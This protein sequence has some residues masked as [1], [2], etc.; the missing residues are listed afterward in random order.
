M[1]GEAACAALLPDNRLHLQHGPIDLVIDIEAED[2]REVLAARH[3]A[4]ARF[5]DVLST[6]VAELP[7]LRTR[8]G[9]R[10][11]PLS[12][13]VA[14]RMLAACWPHRDVY[15]T[16]MAA[17]AG[18]V[19]DEI[20][21]ASV[22]DRTLR[23]VAVNNGGDIALHLAAGTTFRIGLAGIEDAQL[24]GVVAIPAEHAVRGVATSGWRGRSQSLGIADAVTVLARDAASADVA[25]TLVANAVNVDH[26]AVHRLPAHE[27]RDDSD[28]GGLPVTVQVDAL[29][30]EAIAMALDAGARTAHRL[31]RDGWIHAACLRLQGRSSIV[32]A[33]GDPMMNTIR[34][35]DGGVH[36]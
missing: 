28:L 24:H 8:L 1:N 16:P 5:A 32:A 4:I 22:R 19:A 17:V 34:L 2:E 29:P 36:A 9:L 21:A 10:P 7:A 27:V 25:A 13:P 15:L 35:H 30:P 31:Q 18:A 11:P 12:G 14:R 33:R 26:P 3:Q 6:L 23:S 20:L